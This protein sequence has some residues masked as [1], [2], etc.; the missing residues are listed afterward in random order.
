MEKTPESWESEAAIIGALIHDPSKIIEVKEVVLPYQFY[1]KQFEKLYDCILEIDAENK[2]VDILLLKDRLEAKHILEEVGGI[3]FL[4]TIAEDVSVA[5]NV[6]DH[7]VT[8]YDKFVYREVIA[9]SSTIY[10]LGHSSKTIEEA[11][12][13]SEKQIFELSKLIR[14]GD[15]VDWDKT[16]DETRAKINELIKSGGQTS[17]GL[18]TGYQVID[19]MTNGLQKS[20]LIILAARPSVGKTAFAMNIIRNILKNNQGSRALFYSLEMNAEQLLTRWIGMESD[21]DIS[22]L[23]TGALNYE[24]QEQVNYAL[25]N[26]KQER[27]HVDV[28][29]TAGISISQLRSKARKL[30]AEKGLDLIVIDYLQLITVSTRIESRQQEV[31]LISREL[32]AMAKELNVPVVALSQLSR[33]VESRVDKKPMMSDIRESGSIEQD[34]DIIMMLYRPEYYNNEGVEQ[35]PEYETNI[36]G[37]TYLSIV[38]HRNGAIGDVFLSFEKS[39]NRFIS[40]VNIDEQY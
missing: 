14:S 40:V 7:A 11:I 15:F 34:A 32:K 33:G 6:I 24:E 39:T 10:Q 22:K 30:A 35:R 13:E 12:T 5:T 37:F 17:E 8:V 23:R 38:K 21:V 1:Y 31:S 27:F 3:D 20:D 25:D 19:K 2:R 26:L 18:K 28:D 36:E 29:D 9:K 4:A 16:I